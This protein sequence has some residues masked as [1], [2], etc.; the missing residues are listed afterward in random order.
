MP[1][2]A[3]IIVP[4]AFHHVMA[5]GIDGRDLFQDEED[6]RRFIK[7]LK[8]GLAL[9]GHRLYAWALIIGVGP[10]QRVELSVNNP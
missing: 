2:K 1:R 7:L 9:G 8:E 10:S 5:R 3:R 6:R 4:G